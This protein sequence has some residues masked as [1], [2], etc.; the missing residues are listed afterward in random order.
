MYQNAQKRDRLQHGS[1]ALLPFDGLV[2]AR[3]G[4]IRAPIFADHQNAGRT[5]GLCLSLVY[6]QFGAKPATEASF[7]RPWTARKGPADPDAD[8]ALHLV[9]GPVHILAG[10]Y[11]P[12]WGLASS[13]N[14]LSLSISPT[15]VLASKT[16]RKPLAAH[17]FAPSGL[18]GCENLGQLLLGE[19]ARAAKLRRA[20]PRLPQDRPKR[21]LIILPHR[22]VESQ[23]PPRES[24]NLDPTF[25]VPSHV[26]VPCCTPCDKQDRRRS[27]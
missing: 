26:R 6:W 16:R 17:A 23:H 13:T 12:R 9:P 18:P 2:D 4:W 14:P 8:P 21:L 11:R 25:G 3:G 15:S 19:T 10:T 27:S 1:N 20:V 5:R 24:S 22:D 7:G